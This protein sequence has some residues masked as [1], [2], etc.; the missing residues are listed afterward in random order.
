[1]IDPARAAGLVATIGFRFARESYVAQ[2]EGGA[3]AIARG[4]SASAD[5]ALAGEPPAI[6]AAVY[7]GVAID[8]L[9][10]DGALTV[11][12]DRALAARFTT[13]FPL[14]EK[15]GAAD[16]HSGLGRSGDKT[17]MARGLRER[18]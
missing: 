13:L 9:E 2:I 14:P 7:G 17:R 18:F 4:D 12:G 16:R 8:A 5:A 10:R 3:I 11:I 6:A 15:V 1:M